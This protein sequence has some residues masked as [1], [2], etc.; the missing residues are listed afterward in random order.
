M[1]QVD[2][3]IGRNY[4]VGHYLSMRPYAGLRS[5]WIFQKYNIDFNGQ[6][7]G[8]NPITQ[9]NHMTN[10]YWGIGFCGGIGTDWMFTRR[11]SLYGNAGMALMLG[12]FDVNQS[13]SQ[14]DLSIFKISKSF[15]TGRPVFDLGL[16]LKWFSTF[17]K[18]KMAFTLKAGYEYHLYCN[19]NKFLQSNGSENLELFNPVNGDL[20]Y[21]GGTLSA[22]FD[23]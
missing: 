19:Q 1:N 7:V 22:R 20:Y 23:F 17:C 2:L 11:F 16:G 10:R 14:D 18:D 21:Q 12:F 13:G 9:H 4:F 5:A 3:D 8:G 15:R 6:D